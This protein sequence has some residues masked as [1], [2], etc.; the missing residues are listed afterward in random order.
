MHIE[1]GSEKL[2]QSDPPEA[3]DSRVSE[4]GSDSDSSER[5]ERLAGPYSLKDCS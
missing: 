1:A 5:R 3:E 4:M 2:R